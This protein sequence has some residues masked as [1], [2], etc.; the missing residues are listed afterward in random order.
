MAVGWWTEVVAVHVRDA[1][2][3]FR[4]F[5]R[6]TRHLEALDL[7]TDPADGRP[8]T[9]HDLDAL[10]EPAQR[11]MRFMGVVGRPRDWS[12]RAR[13][14]GKIRGAPDKAWMPFTAWQYNT[15]LRVTRVFEMRIDVAGLVPMYGSDTYIDGRGRMHG[16]VANL[17]TVVDGT[18]RE[19]DLGELVTY[20]NDACMVA[21]SMLLRPSVSFTG[22]DDA[23]FDVTLVDSGNT[24][25]ARVSV[26][27]DGR[28]VD[29]STED[30]WYASPN[31]LIQARWSTPV[32]AWTRHGDRPLPD[33]GPAIWHLDAGPFEYAWG[34]F[35]PSSIDRNIAPALHARRTRRRVGA[36]A[37]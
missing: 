17:I 16:K 1:I 28:L 13:L 7:P 20:L 3:G 8:V 9:G 35:D 29:F 24:V 32:S 10:P 21:P 27:E 11:F 2:Y 14:E 25:T 23:S 26:G 4:S 12:F 37:G 31:G 30:R 15:S 6:F 5:E 34:R 19:F 18:G 33:G 22:V 36:A